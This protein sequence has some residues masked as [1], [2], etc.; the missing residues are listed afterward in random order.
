MTAR[1]RRKTGSGPSATALIAWVGG[2]QEVADASAGAVG[3]GVHAWSSGR[4]PGGRAILVGRACGLVAGT[5]L[6][7]GS[8]LAGAAQVGDGSLA[9]QGAPLP[10]Y[11]PVGPDAGSGLDGYGAQ[12]PADRAAA[13]PDAVSAQALAPTGSALRPRSGQVHRNKPVSLDVPA[14]HGS[15]SPAVQRPWGSPPPATGQA[16]TG[17]IAPMKPVLDPAASGVAQ[18]GGVLA[19]ATPR[20]EQPRLSTTQRLS[21]MQSVLPG[22]HAVAPL[23]DKAT[24]PAMAMLSALLP[25]A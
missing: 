6:A 24:Q 16:P 21:T 9:G 25:I 12:A 10:S 22:T 11:T 7:C 23:V 19:P 5:L 8:V 2:G 3:S 4:M 18:V 1:R 20:E 17:P 13:A 14:E 15:P